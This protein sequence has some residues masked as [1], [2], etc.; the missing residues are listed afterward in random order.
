MKIE[1]FEGIEHK[2]FMAIECSKCKN[3]IELSF[4][5]NCRCVNQINNYK[6]DE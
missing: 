5:P 1:D 2:I 6:E 3:V 4:N